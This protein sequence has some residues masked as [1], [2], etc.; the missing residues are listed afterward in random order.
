MKKLVFITLILFFTSINALL[1]ARFA[2]SHYEKR[3]QEQGAVGGVDLVVAGENDMDATQRNITTSRATGFTLA[4]IGHHSL[5]EDC[6]L[7]IRDKVYDVSS[8]IN[9]HPGGADK[10]VEKCGQ[11]VTGIFA[12]LHSNAAWDLLSA[13][14][15]GDVGSASQN[16]QQFAEVQ[17][18]MLAIAD[19]ISG[20]ESVT[21]MLVNQNPTTPVAPSSNPQPQSTHMTLSLAEAAKHSVGGDCW[22]VI[23][24]KVYDVSSYINQHPGGAKKI[25]EKC[26]QEVGGI[27]GAI[28][29]NFAWDLLKSYLIGNIGDTVTISTQPAP[30]TS[31]GQTPTPQP[32]G[33]LEEAIQQQFP[34]ATVQKIKTEDDGRAKV[35]LI[36]NG[37]FYKVVFNADYSIKDIEEKDDD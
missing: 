28:H 33:S 23:N 20:Q 8:Y 15:I 37:D 32:S 13:Y 9:Q 10:I 21:T 30:T 19:Q 3:A 4:S 24:N 18:G 1:A 34:G 25:L 11:E 31:Q 22:L 7:V 5:Q 2:V 17:Q 14:Y 35:D 36:H 16:D 26:G 27:F 6:W 12:A 29:S